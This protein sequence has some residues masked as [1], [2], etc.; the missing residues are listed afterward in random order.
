M[1]ERALNFLFE[2]RKVIA[3]SILIVEF[4]TILF[5][6]F[7]WKNKDAMEIIWND[8]Q[9]RI[10]DDTGS[11]QNGYYLD[12]SYENGSRIVSDILKLKQGMYRVEIWYQ[13]EGAASAEIIYT[14][15]FYQYYIS[16]RIP[17][18]QGTDYISCDFYVDNEERDL[19]FQAKL[20]SEATEGDYLLITKVRIST[21]P[22]FAR[23]ETIK[24]I[25]ILAFI[26]C[27]IVLGIYW[28]RISEKSRKRIKWIAILTFLSSLP[29]MTDYLINEQDLNF[30]LTRLEGLKEGLMTGEFPVKI[31]PGWLNEN[32]YAVSVFY[33]DLFLYL[34]AILRVF[35]VPI[36]TCYK[37]YVVLINLCT[38]FISFYSFSKIGKSD[39]IGMICSAIYTFAIY[40]LTCIYT[41]SAVGEYTAICFMPLI[42]YGLWCIYQENEKEIKKGMFPFIL[43]FTGIIQSHIISF[44][45][46]VF[47]TAFT[48]VILFKK[49]FCKTRFWVL[50]KS[51]GITILLNLW[52]LVPMLHYMLT[53]PLEIN[54]AERYAPYRQQERGLFLGQLFTNDYDILEMSKSVDVGISGEMAL[55]IGLAGII[56]L[57]SGMLLHT[58]EE[59]KRE[60]YLCMTILVMGML[61][62]L[63]VFP[64]TWLADN[65][66]FLKTIFSSIQFP[67]RFL[68]VVSLAVTW[69]TCILLRDVKEEKASV[70]GILLVVISLIE[71]VSFQSKILKEAFPSR[72]YQTGNIT[73]EEVSGGEYLPIG[74]D[75]EAYTSQVL[76]DTKSVEA[77]I[78]EKEGLRKVLQVKNNSQ[79]A[80]MIE[81][82]TIN[83]E[84]FYAR[85]MESNQFMEIQ[86]GNSGKLVL[87]IPEGFQG[88][89][90]I[91]F[92]QPWLWRVAECVSG[93][94]MV[95]ILLKF[96]IKKV[97]S[98]HKN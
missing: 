87:E 92:S 40:R 18:R 1:R 75:E 71:A 74:A 68:T 67:W 27:L 35:A 63:H 7:S 51:T 45:I 15:H 82:P 69:L 97:R 77:A 57:A 17:F 54:S 30:H 86:T 48:C 12:T 34:P 49:T 32:G 58:S 95:V 65:I 44:E 2:K 59:K 16:G 64:Y 6:F 79:K 24:W 70:L 3:L 10:A 33:G 29:L 80:Q 41:R 72:I 56:I 78:I 61:F 96:R 26:D 42:L 39:R 4:I 55:S 8:S 19:Q 47:F 5:V 31:Q 94:T 66:P 53:Q 50:A 85:N 73:F 90:L 83:Y 43:G 36:Q 38:A 14:D 23:Y 46:A 60:K 11:V 84:G 28:K 22:Y 76:H 9:L 20:G 98:M 93:L 25:G 52:F 62:S 88:K 13:C 91:D 37:I 89:I 81:V 21:S